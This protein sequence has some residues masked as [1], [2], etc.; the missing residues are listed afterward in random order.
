MQAQTDRM[1]PFAQWLELFRTL[2]L[3]LISLFIMVGV[4]DVLL[5]LQPGILQSVRGSWQDWTLQQ[6]I[7]TPW[8]RLLAAA[9]SVAGVSIASAI[10]ATFL[11]GV[12][13]E[14]FLWLAPAW[15]G[16]LAFVLARMPIVLPLPASTPLFASASG[17]AI[18]GGATFLQQRSALRTLT[19]TF[20]IVTPIALL[21]A[22]YFGQFDA[23]GA[24]PRFDAAAGLAMFVLV[25]TAI[26]A[27]LI[28]VNCNAGVQAGAGAPREL[29]EQMFELLERVKFSETRASLAEQQLQQL[30]T[31]PSLSLREDDAD[32]ARIRPHAARQWQLW[33]ALAFVLGCGASLYFASYVP[34]R[35]RLSAELARSRRQ[36]EQQAQTLSSLRAHFAEE[37]AA[38]TQQL[39]A[40][41][42][43]PTAEPSVAPAALPSQRSEP[44]KPQAQ[45]H[46]SSARVS[47]RTQLQPASPEP[48]TAND[49]APAEP[50]ERTAPARKPVANP[51]GNSSSND[52]LEGLDGM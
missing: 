27:A 2:P 32:F 34:L 42:A 25:L 24:T 15:V 50:S 33:A 31:A 51:A 17:L 48:A 4:V 16:L 5:A 45:S 39:S 23:G 19:A 8:A 46:R 26:G 14:P 36:A 3:V 28:A 35:G 21:C 43:Q 52:P 7:S 9:V 40:A 41:R 29:G 12:Q 22:G 10:L 37:R 18:L 11:R 6:G 44:A 38:L 30:R 20:L 47:R 13:S 49:S 1:K